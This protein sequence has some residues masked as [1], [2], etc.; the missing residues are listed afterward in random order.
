MV[1]KHYDDLKRWDVISLEGLDHVVLNNMKLPE[2]FSM[3]M[4]LIDI[5]PSH[6][7]EVVSELGRH[8]YVDPIEYQ[9]SGNG[10]KKAMDIFIALEDN[11]EPYK[12]RWDWGTIIT[13]LDGVFLHEEP[14]LYF[15]TVRQFAQSI[16]AEASD[17]NDLAAK[18]SKNKNRTN[19]S[20][21]EV[22]NMILGLFRYLHSS[23]SLQD[24]Y[25]FINSNS[26]VTH[27]LNDMDNCLED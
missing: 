18:L 2:S 26:L 3:E 14:F 19:E 1:T 4:D 5:T 22:A 24:W 9:V 21:L 27:L 6:T 8:N 16:E 7:V 11:D 10:F 15:L 12:L 17:Y 13:G 20:V 23:G 25:I